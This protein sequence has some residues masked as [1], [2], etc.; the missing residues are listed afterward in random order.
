MSMM[1]AVQAQQCTMAVC[2]AG[3]PFKDVCDDAGVHQQPLWK[4]DGHL[5]GLQLLDAPDSLVDLQQLVN[6]SAGCSGPHTH[7]AQGA[8]VQSEA[9]GLEHAQPANMHQTYAAVYL[10]VVVCR[11]H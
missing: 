10:K 4:L 9:P 7:Q 2:L 3:L 1:Q 11:Q 8:A 6:V 5:L